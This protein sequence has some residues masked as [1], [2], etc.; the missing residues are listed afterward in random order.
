MKDWREGG[1]KESVSWQN[2]WTRGF[3]NTLNTLQRR[4]KEMEFRDCTSEGG[5]GRNPLLL[6]VGGP[7]TTGKATFLVPLV[8]VLLASIDVD[9]HVLRL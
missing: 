5:Q 2:L 8:V 7:S 9:E 3:D 6:A 4:Q 1:S